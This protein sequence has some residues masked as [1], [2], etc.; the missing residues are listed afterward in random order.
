MA[1]SRFE[2]ADRISIV[3]A[4][5]AVVLCRCIALLGRP[6]RASSEADSSAA[7]RTAYSEK[8]SGRT[9]GLPRQRCTLLDISCFHFLREE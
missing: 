9:A 5:A 1:E 8:V 6:V 3:A 7:S 2:I 4:I